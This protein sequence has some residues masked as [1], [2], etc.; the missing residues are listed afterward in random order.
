VWVEA[1]PGTDRKD[2]PDW[3]FR[4][5]GG[6]ALAAAALRSS[7]NVAGMTMPAKIYD[8]PKGR[9]PQIPSMGGPFR[10]ADREIRQ[11]ASWTSMAGPASSTGNTR[12]PGS[13]TS[14]PDRGGVFPQIGRGTIQDIVRLCGPHIA[15]PVIPYGA[16]H[17][18]SR[19]HVNC[20]VRAAYPL[21]VARHEQSAGRC[22][23]EDLDC[24]VAARHHPQGALNEYL[25]RTK[26]CFF[27]IDPGA[28]ASLGGT[29]AATRCS[30]HQ[31]GALQA[32]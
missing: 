28:D 32:R 5:C 10:G 2:P 7:G 25:R 27:P 13:S 9:D 3:R 6:G 15:C 8:A 4:K 20:A 22:M 18:R 23:A 19:G 24:V 17:V 29:L 31:R 30:G 11:T 14:R 16:G 1:R 12:Q 26:G 21:D